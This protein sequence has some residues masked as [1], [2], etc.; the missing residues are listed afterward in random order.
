MNEIGMRS[1]ARGRLVFLSTVLLCA[2]AALLLP[3]AGQAKV[4][5]Y[6]LRYGPVG[7]G[8]FNVALPKVPVKAPGVDGY[9]VG[10]TA[11]LVDARGRPITIRDVMLHHIVFHRVGRSGGRWPC[12]SPAGEPIYGT[13]EERQHLRLPAR[14]RLSRP[15]RRPV[16]HHRDADEPQPAEAVQRLHPATAS[17]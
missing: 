4:K 3:A 6:T 15:Q 8:D 14:L 9:V 5:T 12:S 10:M 1:G 16:A 7:M 13:G 2:V 11:S 17:P